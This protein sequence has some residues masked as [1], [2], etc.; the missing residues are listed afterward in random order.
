M[1]GNGYELTGR[2]IKFIPG[3]NLLE[4]QVGDT[5]ICDPEGNIREEVIWV[6]PTY[7]SPGQSFDTIRW[8]KDIRMRE[9]REYG[10]SAELTSGR[11]VNLV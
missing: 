4:L 2:E 5:L 1:M 11:P 8:I 6:D 9:L 10:P 7:E 3:R